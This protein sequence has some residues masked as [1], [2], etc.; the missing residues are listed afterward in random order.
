MATSS[1]PG[2]TPCDPAS[3]CL[4]LKIC[5]EA[6]SSLIRRQKVTAVVLWNSGLIHMRCRSCQSAPGSRVYPGSISVLLQGTADHHQA[7]P[8]FC[9]SQMPPVRCSD[10]PLEHGL[11]HCGKSQALSSVLCRLAERVPIP[12]QNFA[13][14]ANPE[15]AGARRDRAE[16]PGHPVLKH[17]GLCFYHQ[18][19]WAW[20]SA[21]GGHPFSSLTPGAGRTPALLIFSEYGPTSTWDSHQDGGWALGGNGT[22]QQG[23]QITSTTCDPT[24]LVAPKYHH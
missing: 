18:G 2:A 22:T 11:Q 9:R 13:Q 17:F 8:G 5:N 7:G 4:P 19:F 10:L 6:G 24:S 12:T 15:R 3:G 23:I 21:E 16:A 14:A 1:L 20:D